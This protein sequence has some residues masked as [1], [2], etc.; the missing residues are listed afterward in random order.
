MFNFLPNY[1]TKLLL[2]HVLGVDNL[3]R[4][5]NGV[6]GQLNV[7]VSPQVCGALTPNDRVIALL[8]CRVKQ[9]PRSRRA[10]GEEHEYPQ[11]LHHYAVIFDQFGG[12]NGIRKVITLQ[13][14][15]KFMV[16]STSNRHNQSHKCT[17][18]YGKRHTY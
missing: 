7:R 12:E 18:P 8:V 10:I 14:I 6:C 3:C 15:K 13:T 16:D 9:I 17:Y 4:Q 5:H 11:V 1:I 2:E